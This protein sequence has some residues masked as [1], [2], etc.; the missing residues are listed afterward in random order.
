MRALVP[1]ALLFT[2]DEKVGTFSNGRVHAKVA[3]ADGDDAFLTSA[4]LTG[5]ALEKNM[6]AGVTI[7]GGPI[8]A[9]LRSHLLALI[10]TK[11]VNRV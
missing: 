10:E 9:D 11:I 6:E 2:W 1:S 7:R 4:N 3:V 5:H 8:P